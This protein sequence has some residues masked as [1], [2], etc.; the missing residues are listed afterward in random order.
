MQTETS[1]VRR[2]G[3]PVGCMVA[4]ALLSG[5]G[6]SAHRSTSGTG[7]KGFPTAYTITAGIPT[8]A[9]NGRLTQKGALREAGC[10]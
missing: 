2:A 7:A 5:C 4:V 6:S 8:E 9:T 10:G 3:W 1:F